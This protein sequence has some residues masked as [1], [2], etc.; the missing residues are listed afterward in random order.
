M[1]ITDHA[2][3]AALHTRVAKHNIYGRLA[4][5][6]RHVSSTSSDARHRMRVLLAQSSEAYDGIVSVRHRIG[7]AAVGADGF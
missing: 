1:G 5:R 3:L 4:K 2:T 6:N 7:Y